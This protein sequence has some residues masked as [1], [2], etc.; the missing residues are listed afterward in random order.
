MRSRSRKLVR[1]PAV[2]GGGTMLEDPWRRGAGVAGA[3]AGAGVE[4]SG[5]AVG[6]GRGLSKHSERYALP[7][8]YSIYRLQ[9]C[10]FSRHMTHG[11]SM[12]DALWAWPPASRLPPPSLLRHRGAP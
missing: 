8:A 12:A 11:T 7:L 4:A 5:E 6:S 1:A 10:A 2:E 3:R 9:T